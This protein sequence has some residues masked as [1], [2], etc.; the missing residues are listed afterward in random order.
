MFGLNSTDLI[1]DSGI[2]PG[3][4]WHKTVRHFAL[5]QTFVYCPFGLY[6]RAWS[7]IVLDLFREKRFF[8]PDIILLCS[9]I[10]ICDRN[11]GQVSPVEAK[12]GQKYWCP[13]VQTNQ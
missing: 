12:G 2:K 13:S 5:E 7:L 8:L 4:L 9:T 3:P 1:S 11:T 10:V 6:V